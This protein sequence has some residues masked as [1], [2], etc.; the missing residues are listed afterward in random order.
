MAKNEPLVQLS[1]ILQE[2]CPFFYF[3]K[4]SMLRSLIQIFTHRHHF[5]ILKYSKFLKNI[6]KAALG[7]KWMVDMFS[8]RHRPLQ[9]ALRIA[10]SCC[11]LTEMFF[12]PEIKPSSLGQ[13]MVGASK[14]TCMQSKSN[15]P[16]HFLPVCVRYYSLTLKSYN[17]SAG[18]GKVK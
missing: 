18:C 13:N 16:P 11:I 1:F 7:M 14:I 5:Y 6:C 15:L 8:W 4:P 2:S 9:S 10:V 17:D 12:I 3:L